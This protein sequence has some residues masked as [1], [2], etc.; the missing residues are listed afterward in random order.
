M[1][2]FL[3]LPSI[4]SCL[5]GAHTKKMKMPH[6]PGVSGN[7]IRKLII[8]NMG[9]NEVRWKWDTVPPRLPPKKNPRKGT[10]LNGNESIFQPY[11]FRGYVSFHGGTW[12]VDRIMSR[13]ASSTNFQ[14]VAIRPLFDKVL[15]CTKRYA[16]HPYHLWSGS[17]VMP[18]K[19]VG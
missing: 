9:P 17:H 10:V 11:I 15:I 16:S 12:F 6:H 8:L 7:I 2:T 1:A 14:F 18:K 3:M 4:H 19:N 5:K 13:F